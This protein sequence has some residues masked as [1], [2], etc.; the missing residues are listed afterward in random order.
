MK[1]S[2]P[3]GGSI[4]KEES[5]NISIRTA[6]IKDAQ[7]LLD[8]YA[9]YV[10]NTAITF[11]FEVP[12]LT[13]FEQ[14]IE[15]TLQNYPYLVAE[16]DGKIVGYIYAGR[17]RARAAY[18]WSASTSVYIHRQYHRL[19]I[20][21]LLY[22]KLEDILRRQNIVNVYAGVADPVEEDKYLTRNSERFHE[23]MGY[24][25]VARF[26]ACGSKFGRW[27]N[28]IEMEK[29]IGEQTC[30]PKEFIPFGEWML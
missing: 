23:A 11:E 28:L 26:Q 2:Y 5:M 27:Y 3:S 10:E 19:G 24:R 25:T 8:I 1:T 4:R 6:T 9:Y 30:P 20:G 16:L 14:R 22:E 17:F 15:N 29:I 18:N 21:K 7:E 12:A 13:E